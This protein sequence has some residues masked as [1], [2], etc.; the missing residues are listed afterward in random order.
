[1]P[2]GDFYDGLALAEAIRKFA[3]HHFEAKHRHISEHEYRLLV[4]AAR[5]LEAD[6]QIRPRSFMTAAV[7][8][9]AAIP[10]RP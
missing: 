6:R 4:G 8:P 5:T 3:E 10:E 9:P 2:K 1:M 7:S